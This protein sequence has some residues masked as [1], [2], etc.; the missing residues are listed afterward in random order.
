MTLFGICLDFA[1]T[2]K[3][4]EKG[5]TGWMDGAE[6]IEEYWREWVEKET[7]FVC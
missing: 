6:K 2:V 3:E 1:K 5:L 4:V 7:V